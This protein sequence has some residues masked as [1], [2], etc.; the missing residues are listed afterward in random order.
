MHCPV[1]GSENPD[2]AKFCFNCGSNFSD[3][4]EKYKTLDMKL[5]KKSKFI[6][7]STQRFLRGLKIIWLEF[8]FQIKNLSNKKDINNDLEDISAQNTNKRT[9]YAR[10]IF[11]IIVVVIFLVFF[12]G[13]FAYLIAFIGGV[14]LSESIYR[15]IT[16][17]NA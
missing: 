15:L 10:I 3:L 4:A 13:L 9:Y 5:N 14:V 8:I 7:N 12:R 16:N 6:K 17:S 11:G 1:C 2:Q